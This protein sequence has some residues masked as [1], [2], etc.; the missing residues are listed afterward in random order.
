MCL[1]Y[2]HKASFID[3]HK[4]VCTQTGTNAYIETNI[5]TRIQIDKIF[6]PITF[7]NLIIPNPIS[8][9]WNCFPTSGFLKNIFSVLHF[10]QSA[11][12][13]LMYRIKKVSWW[14]SKNW[15]VQEPAKIMRKGAT[16][17]IL[18]HPLHFV[19]QS[20]L[21]FLTYSSRSHSERFCSPVWRESYS[22]QLSYLDS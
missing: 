14:G 1:L 11:P 18:P 19:R 16:F 22:Q 15:C 13:T 21:A 4:Y 12:Y 10:F 6:F 17:C 20:L 3:M 7:T 2:I 5:Q 8:S 9:L